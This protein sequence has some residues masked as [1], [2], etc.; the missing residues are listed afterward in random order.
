MEPLITIPHTDPYKEKKE[1][2][3]L[4]QMQI[5]VI[6]EAS[7]SRRSQYYESQFVKCDLNPSLRNASDTMKSQYI[8]AILNCKFNDLFIRR[9]ANLKKRSGID[10]KDI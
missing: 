5:I 10:R 9:H 2:K 8:N 4:F 1:H 3:H 6:G 7:K